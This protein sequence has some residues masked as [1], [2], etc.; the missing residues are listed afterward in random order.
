MTETPPP[1]AEPNEVA[2]P[3]T[4]DPDSGVLNLL[5][6]RRFVLL[7]VLFAVILGLLAWFTMPREEDPRLPERMALLVIP[8]PGA[9]ALRIEQQVLEPLQEELA[10]VETLKEVETTARTDV[11]IVN[12]SL[13]DSIGED[14]VDREWDEVE[15]AIARARMEF[16]DGVLEPDLDRHILDT[17]TIV[18]AITGSADRLELLET[19]RRLETTLLRYADVK[20]VD[21]V[22]HPGEQITVALDDS[23]ARRLGLAPA[24]LAQGLAQRNVTTPGGTIDV[25]DRSAAIRPLAEFR[26][27]EE[28]RATP[29]PLPSGAAVRLGDI[30]RVERT[31]EEPAPERMRLDG[32]SAVALGIVPMPGLDLAAFGRAMRERF[33]A[34]RA[35]AAPLTLTAITYQ[36][37]RVEARLADLGQ[38]LLLGM[39]IVAGVLFLA[40]GPR[41]GVVVASIVPLVALASL[42]AFA[43]AGGVLHQIS[44]AAFIIALGMLVDNAIVVAENVQWRIDRGTSRSRAAR[45]AVAELVLPLGAATGTTLAAFLPMLLASGITADF[46][47][48]LPQVIM[49]T[50]GLSYLFA[51]AVTPAACAMLLKRR[52]PDG[53]D[54][55]AP[56]RTSVFSVPGRML[57]RLAID[58]PWVILLV[59]FLAVGTAGVSMRFLDQQFFPST[60]RNQLLVDLTLPEGTPLERT[61]AVAREVERLVA[62]SD[63]VVSV[64]AFVGRGAPRFYY[65]V[66]QRPSEPNLAQLLVTTESVDA[67]GP[68]MSHLRR[69]VPGIA[70]EAE[71]LTRRIEQGPPTPAP[72][73]IRLTGDDLDALYDATQIVLREVRAAPG[74]A[75]VRHTQSLGAPTVITPTNDAAAARVGV[76]RSDVALALLGRTR[77]LP[78][79]QFRG[80][81]EPLPIVVRSRP[82]SHFPVADLPTIDVLASG[83]G[84]LPPGS[85]SPQPRFGRIAPTVPLSQVA[86]VGV[87]WLPAAIHRRNGVRTVSVLAE[88][89]P[90][91]TFSAALADIAPRLAGLDLPGGVDWE[92]GGSA[93]EAGDAQTGQLLLLPF[94]LLLI[95]LILLI[96]FNSYRRVA[97]VLMTIPLAATGVVPGLLLM[98]L[99]FGFMALLGTIALIGV[100]VN[101][102]IVLIDVIELRRAEGRSVADGIAAAVRERTRPIILTTVTTVAGLLPLALSGSTLWP[103]LA[104]AMISGL[105]AS[106]FLTLLALPAAYRLLFR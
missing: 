41:L 91:T 20:S 83:A 50:L 88:T 2:K 15:D 65:N 105:L 84:Q 85:R 27:L 49:L 12:L 55:D 18:L 34:L 95:V 56:Q 10:E 80:L 90:G 48:A 61:D 59:A 104:W 60:D 66:M 8:W 32:E 87:E 17:H 67:V 21:I 45:E 58:R 78:V 46:T 37:E 25:G 35:D 30:A 53:D 26:T 16:P 106:T 42:G 5:T 24:Q 62:G 13:K 29:V 74:T 39:V 93:E 19:A 22:G 94:G 71:L 98:D 68:L 64:A 31:P 11:L 23:T 73:E 70:P 9:D 47:R 52:T 76:S 103:P 102:A 28:L 36:P 3:S 51:I 38:S 14:G 69:V 92:I 100:V 86:D 81:D 54:A 7:M 101:N 57:S 89:L 6:R 43:M 1:N 97:L 33:D 75:D 40:M 79:G 44:I 63:G 99:P 82:G 72:V 96:E 77:G 4:A